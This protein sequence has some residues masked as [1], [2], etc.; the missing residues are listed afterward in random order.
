MEKREEKHAGV[1]LLFGEFRIVASCRLL[2][3]AATLLALPWL[4]PFLPEF[5]RAHLWQ[6]TKRIEGLVQAHACLLRPRSD[7]PDVRHQLREAVVRILAEVDQVLAFLGHPLAD[8]VLERLGRR[9]QRVPA[10]RHSRSARTC[11]DV[12]PELLLH[13]GDGCGCGCVAG[14][15]SFHHGQHL[16]EVLFKPPRV[17]GAVTGNVTPWLVVAAAVAAAALLLLLRH[18]ESLDPADFLHHGRGRAGQ[19]LRQARVAC[20][21]SAVAIHG[22]EEGA[23]PR[24]GSNHFCGW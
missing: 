17:A 1:N 13:R 18:E 23:H 14:R 9:R 8:E 16:L 19:A 12:L 10:R 21:L 5:A 20:C 24:R 3:F 6:N 7:G 2:P 11:E 22:A 4:F 15:Q